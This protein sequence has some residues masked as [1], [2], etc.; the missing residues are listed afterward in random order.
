MLFDGSTVIKSIFPVPK[1]STLCCTHSPLVNLYKLSK[2]ENISPIEFEVNGVTQFPFCPPGE[3]TEE[4]N[5][6]PAE[7]L[8][9][10]PPP[11]CIKP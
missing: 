7:L 2:P 3:F 11:L 6:L 9:Y 10:N 5:P 1:A 8:I 4:L